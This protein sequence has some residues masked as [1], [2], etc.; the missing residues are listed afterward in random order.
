MSVELMERLAAIDGEKLQ[1]QIDRL[2]NYILANVEGEPSQSEGAVDCAIRV[3][4]SFRADLETARAERQRDALDG[5]ATM[6]EANNE[7]VQLRTLL[8]GCHITLSAKD[9]VLRVVAI[10]DSG[11]SR[12]FEMPKTY[13]VLKGVG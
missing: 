7:I 8:D 13:L 6:D 1:E 3:L 9:H 11:E 12:I 2:A 10:S 5:Q 4:G